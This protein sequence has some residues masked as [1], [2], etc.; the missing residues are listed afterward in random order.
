[1]AAAKKWYPGRR[2]IAIFQPHTYSRTKALFEEFSKAFSD[3]DVVL[4]MDIYSS[5]RETDDL[6][7]SSN[8]LSSE[9]QKHHKNVIYTGSFLQ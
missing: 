8:L 7:I 2:I 1:L 4:L 3:A 5:A 6:G 9:I